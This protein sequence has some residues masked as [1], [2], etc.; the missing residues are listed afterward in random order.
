MKTLA[1][2]KNAVAALS[3]GTVLFFS[4]AASASFIMFDGDSFVSQ[5]SMFADAGGI[6]S[7]LNVPTG[8]LTPFEGY[9]F[10][11]SH[12]HN[13]GIG[14]A[15]SSVSQNYGLD[16][17]GEGAIHGFSLTGLAGGQFQPLNAGPFMGKSDSHSLLDVTF[18]LSASAQMMITGM[19]NIGADSFPGSFDALSRIQ[20]YQVSE[21]GDSLIFEQAVSAVGSSSIGELLSLDAGQD[22]RLEV[23]AE[24][25][26]EFDGTIAD[27]HSFQAEYDLNFAVIPA[28]SA[29]ALLGMAGLLGMRRRRNA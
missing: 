4:S 29:L 9:S 14:M 20:L 11:P 7:T 5:A 6:G 23:L 3:A 18:S 21:M 25:S 26:S 10:G 12:S 1:V 24:V 28:P 16:A 15:I 27:L 2:G 22:Y 13:N 17:N 19:L 8:S